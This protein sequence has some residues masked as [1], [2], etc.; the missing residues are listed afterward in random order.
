[1]EPSNLLKLVQPV[2]PIFA[3]LVLIQ[4]LS[5]VL[6]SFIIFKLYGL[7]FNIYRILTHDINNH[8]D[9]GDSEIIASSMDDFYAH[10]H[11]PEKNKRTTHPEPR[12]PYTAYDAALEADAEEAERLERDRLKYNQ[13]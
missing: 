3:C 4:T 7:L 5:L 1:M 2:Q 8:V 10:G 12:A 11:K 13:V 9:I 6:V